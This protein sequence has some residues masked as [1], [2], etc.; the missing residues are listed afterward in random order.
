MW[1]DRH[2]AFVQ[3]AFLQDSFDDGLAI[4]YDPSQRPSEEQ[5]NDGELRKSV[6]QRCEG[7]RRPPG[8]AAA[9]QPC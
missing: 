5:E 9:P 8:G 3:A 7:W 2:P 6:R 1:R 4:V